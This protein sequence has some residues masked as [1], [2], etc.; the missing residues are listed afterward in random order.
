LGAF[1]LHEA[2]YNSSFSL[3][4]LDQR[5]SPRTLEK[6]PYP[7]PTAGINSFLADS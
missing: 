6:E 4:T 5:A 7:N 2:V 3:S 1:F